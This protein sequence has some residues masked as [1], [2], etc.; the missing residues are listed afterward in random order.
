MRT[1]NLNLT[2]AGKSKWAKNR[3]WFLYS[4]EKKERVKNGEEKLIPAAF[5]R[6]NSPSAA[7]LSFLGTT[8]WV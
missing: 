7:I 2:K 8:E 6:V 3:R 5:V 4:G 1:R